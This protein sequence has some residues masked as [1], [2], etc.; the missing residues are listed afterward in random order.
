MLTNPRLW[1]ATS[2]AAASFLALAALY[3]MVVG[4]PSGQIVDHELMLRFSGAFGIDLP[5][6]G[7]F[8][9]MQMPLLMAGFGLVAVLLLVAR[10]AR[11]ATEAVAIVLLTLGA[12]YVL[13]ALLDR[14]SFGVGPLLNSFPSNTV[15]VFSALAVIAF[16]TPPSALRSIVLT[17]SV[18][19]GA[20]ASLA[21]VALQWHRPGDV[22]GAW[23]IA[24]CA[25]GVVRAY[26]TAWNAETILRRPVRGQTAP[27][28][29]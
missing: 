15:A 13:K 18:T 23:L 3:L 25:A 14:P 22:A 2:V 19:V 20:I 4:T 7:W 24:V 16:I 12:A 5:T 10:S 29:G 21:V 1:A 6:A 28:R 17:Y 8:D 9:E 27:H 11:I 26:S